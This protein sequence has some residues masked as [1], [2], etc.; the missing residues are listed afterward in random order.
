MPATSMKAELSAAVK[1][2][3]RSAHEAGK[4]KQYKVRAQKFIERKTIHAEE[5]S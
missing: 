4:K 3:T 1:L 5:T 2:G